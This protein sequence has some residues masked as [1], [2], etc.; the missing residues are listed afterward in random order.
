MEVNR[1]LASLE[2]SWDRGGFPMHILAQNLAVR[3]HH[4]NNSNDLP[5]FNER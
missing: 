3:N 5:Q 1:Y 2:D 4:F